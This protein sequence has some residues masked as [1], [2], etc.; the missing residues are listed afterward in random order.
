[1]VKSSLDLPHSL[2][3]EVDGVVRYSSEYVF[4]RFT[5]TYGSGL[6]LIRSAVKCPTDL[7]SFEWGLY[8]QKVTGYGHDY[9]NVILRSLQ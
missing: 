1:M 4:V 3:K 7:S 8:K 9:V 6:C 2:H 5:S